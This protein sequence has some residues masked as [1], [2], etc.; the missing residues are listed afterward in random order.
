MIPRE[1]DSLEVVEAVMVIE[2]VFETS[3][4]SRDGENFGSPGEIV[5]GLERH[6]SNECPNKAAAGLLRKLVM[7]TDSP[8]LAKGLD[9]AWRREQIAAIIR[10][11]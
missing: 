7:R 3:V 6:L 4:P 8:Q 2:E 5:D 9:G 1:M 11:Q 10:E